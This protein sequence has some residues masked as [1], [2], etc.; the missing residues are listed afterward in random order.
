MKNIKLAG[1]ILLI[2]ANGNLFSGDGTK[3]TKKNVIQ[4]LTLISLWLS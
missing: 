1:I 4:R 3:E 2:M